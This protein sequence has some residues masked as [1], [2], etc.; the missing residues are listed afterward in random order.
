MSIHSSDDFSNNFLMNLHPDKSLITG[1]GWDIAVFAWAECHVWP[2]SMF[3]Y[4]PS[5]RTGACAVPVLDD[6]MLACQQSPQHP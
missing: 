1:P 6:G 5:P 4:P 2:S 3:C